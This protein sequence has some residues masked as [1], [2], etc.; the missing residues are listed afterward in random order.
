MLHALNTRA[1][2]HYIFVP[3]RYHTAVMRQLRSHVYPVVT[4]CEQRSN[5]K[6]HES[7]VSAN[8]AHCAPLYFEQ[9][10]VLC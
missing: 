9:R 5:K 2:L 10:M 8:C 4:S 6:V 1:A 3:K 7:H